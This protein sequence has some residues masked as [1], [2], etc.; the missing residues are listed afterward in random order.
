[1][2]INNGNAHFFVSTVNGSWRGLLVVFSSL[3]LLQISQSSIKKKHKFAEKGRC[4][5]VLFLM[6]FHP[7]LVGNWSSQPRKKPKCLENSIGFKYSSHCLPLE[8]RYLSKCEECN[9]FFAVFAMSIKLNAM[10][11]FCPV[12]GRILRQCL[13]Y[14]LHEF[15]QRLSSRL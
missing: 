11:G 1:M 3:F 10:L 14:W 4:H 7:T 5:E 6:V 2:F 13:R 15:R 9:R 8:F 12:Q